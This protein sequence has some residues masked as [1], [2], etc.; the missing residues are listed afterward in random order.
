MPFG[1]FADY[2]HNT[3]KVFCPDY[4]FGGTKNSVTYILS[5]HLPGKV[6]VQQGIVW[7]VVIHLIEVRDYKQNT[8]WILCPFAGGFQCGFL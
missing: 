1:V 3:I 6:L 4:A 7:N 8:P 2:I 5:C